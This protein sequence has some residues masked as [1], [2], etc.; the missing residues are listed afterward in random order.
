MENVAELIQ[1]LAGL[2]QPYITATLIVWAIVALART[3]AIWKLGV[4]A[5]GSEGWKLA[6]MLLAAGTGIVAGL[7]GW[8]PPVGPGLA[9][10]VGTGLLVAGLAIVNRDLGSRALKFQ[11][12][13]KEASETDPAV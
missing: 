12:A 6:F 10:R 4:E 5:V 8:A 2:I 7:V 11:K 13:R 1:G 3:A 9:G